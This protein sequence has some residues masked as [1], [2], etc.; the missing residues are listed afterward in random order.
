MCVCKLEHLR[1]QGMNVIFTDKLSNK[2]SSPNIVSLKFNVV[3]IRLNWYGNVN[4]A[5]QK[6]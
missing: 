1:K 4:K 3:T 6:Y 2:N 5:G